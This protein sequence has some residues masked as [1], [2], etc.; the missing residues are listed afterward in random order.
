MRFKTLGY[1]NGCYQRSW[2]RQSDDITMLAEATV[3]T[4]C[5][6]TEA[7][8]TW[9][10]ATALNS[11]SE[12]VQVQQMTTSAETTV[13]RS[14]SYKNPWPREIEVHKRSACYMLHSLCLQL[15]TTTVTSHHGPQ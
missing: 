10:V 1:G 14:S 9:L 6:R 8:A 12:R 7:N 13:I 11:W 3:M 4:S 15:I 2:Q 5:R